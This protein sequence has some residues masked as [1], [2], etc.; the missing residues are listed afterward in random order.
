MKRDACRPTFSHLPT[1]LL[2]I[3]LGV[4][5]VGGLL[6]VAQ[7]AAAQDNCIQDVWQAHGNNQNLT[8]TAND[9]TLSS[10][11]N[12][13]IITGGQCD[14]DTGRCEC[15]AGQTVT[16][17]ADF[18]MTL[19]TQTRYDVGFYIAEDGDPNNDGALTGECS[20]TV[21]NA[22]NTAN[23]VQ[24]DAP[25]PP[26]SDLCGDIDAAHN[27]LIVTSNLISLQCPAEGEQ[28]SVP[29]CTTWRQPGSNEVCRTRDDAFPGSPSKCN[30]GD[31]DIP[32]F[33]A[34]VEFSVTKDTVPPA[35]PTKTVPES[36]GS[37]TYSVSVHNDSTMAALTLTRSTDPATCAAA[38]PPS[39]APCG[40]TDDKYGDITVVHA[41]NQSC[42][43][44]ATPG[45]CEAVTA[46]TC[47]PDGN[48]ATC[49]IGGAI[50]ASG[51]CSCTFT[52]TVPAGDTGGSFTDVVTAC[53]SNVA[54]PEV[55]KADDATVTYTEVPQAPTLTKTA[56]GTQ[57][58]IDVTY[59]VVVTNNPGDD[60]S[61]SPL[62]LTAL[63]DDTY[64]SITTVHDNVLSTTCSVP[65][66]IAVSGNYTCSFV[67]RINSCNT[68][69]TDIVTGS[70]TAEGTTYTLSDSATVVVSPPTT[71]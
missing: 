29:F 42:T 5:A 66:T 65:Q 9:V 39:S 7:P 68:T 8:C 20:A 27:P 6:L 34:P 24:L 14:P 60:P 64:G 52:G 3:L 49:E 63:S 4:L 47:V 30:C 57:C 46:T 43:G 31:I 19:T 11:S 15:F 28:V 12:V 36:G 16:F 21:S 51:T 70:A 45:V 37:V 32:I 18:A 35:P 13:K 2:P 25:T 22:L 26:T 53:G 38:T 23:F 67:G 55:C 10:A 40:L 59:T 58:Q 17:T 71:P 33:A 44:S 61:P 56:T 41:A 62:A 1:R 54:N 48:T 50:A 69:V